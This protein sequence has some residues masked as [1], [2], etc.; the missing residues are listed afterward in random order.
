[1]SGFSAGWLELR[2]PYD[3]RARN[4]DVLAAVAAAFAGR[5]AVSTVDLGCGTGATL[6]AV[7]PHLP[8]RQVSA[9][10][11]ER[12][13]VEVAA[14][15]LPVYAAL[16]YDG[17]A[18][19]EPADAFDDAVI[20]AVNRHQRRDKGFGPALGP[21][22]AVAAIARFERVRYA[23]VEGASDWVFAPHDHKIQKDV[24]AGWASAAREFGEL[25]LGDIVAWL[26]RR[27]DLIAAGRSTMRIGHMD[28]FARP[29]GL[30]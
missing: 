21:T 23:V 18:V 27:S 22:A 7:A 20:A 26:T 1:M 8:A 3:A 19:L 14:H 9:E 16:T 11:L 10:W 13:A 24:L 2:E 25:P 5:S 6:R 29:I 17:R 28:L 4:R 12:F 15:R 30:R